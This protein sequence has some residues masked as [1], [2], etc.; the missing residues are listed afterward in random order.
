MVGF[1]EPS[2]KQNSSV[3]AALAAQSGAET[4]G[5]TLQ[6]YNHGAASGRAGSCCAGDDIRDARQVADRLG[7][8]RVTVVRNINEAIKQHEVRIWLTGHVAECI[9]LEKGLKEAF[10][11][12]E[13]V[14]VPEPSHADATAKVIGA[15]AGMYVSDQLKSN[16]CIGVGWGHTLQIGRAHV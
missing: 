5:I 8:G 13:A 9:E 6:L 10:N 12:M 16:A 3:V 14:V 11:L 15:A 4:I 7:I 1:V 2:L